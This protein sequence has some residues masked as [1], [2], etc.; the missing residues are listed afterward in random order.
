MMTTN[1][2]SFTFCKG[3][4]QRLGFNFELCLFE[5]SS[6]NLFIAFLDRSRRGNFHECLIL[7]MQK[8]SSIF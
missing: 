8:I 1:N 3:P 2:D 7:K 5:I 6:I 4:S